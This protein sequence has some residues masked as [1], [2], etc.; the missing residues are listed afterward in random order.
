MLISI[1]NFYKIFFKNILFFIFIILAIYLS[2]S[3]FGNLLSNYILNT[4]ITSQGAFPRLFLNILASIIFLIFYKKIKI[5]KYEKKLYLNISILIFFL[6][7]LTFSYSTFVDRLQIYFLPFQLIVFSSLHNITRNRIYKFYIN[8]F[9]ILLFFLYLFTWLEF[10]NSSHRWLPYKSFL[11]GSNLSYNYNTDQLLSCD[12][13]NKIYGFFI[14][15][16]GNI[17]G[18]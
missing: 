17:N 5:S 14:K 2:K 1:N 3:D 4:T 8:T 13:Y 6:I 18:C 9:I 15:N 11:L 16:D 12:E 7:I 10:S